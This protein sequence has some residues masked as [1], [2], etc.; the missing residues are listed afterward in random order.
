[1]G[2]EGGEHSPGVGVCREGKGWEAFLTD[3]VIWGIHFNESEAQYN[4]P[5]TS[6]NDVSS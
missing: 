3:K 6:V 1:M 4:Y 5:V 2:L